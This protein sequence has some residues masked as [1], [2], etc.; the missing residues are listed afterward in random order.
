[1]GSNE[2]DYTYQQKQPQ[3]AKVNA[4][5]VIVLNSSTDSKTN[6]SAPTLSEADQQDLISLY[7]VYFGAP[8][9][10]EWN[11][12]GGTVSKIV[13]ALSY[14]TDQRRRVK[15]I[16]TNYHITILVGGKYN[17][18]RKSGKNATTIK[19]SSHFQQPTVDLQLQRRWSQF[20]RG[21]TTSMYMVCQ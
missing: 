8:S 6:E 17:P 19:G 9:S 3:T 20:D 16:I 12:E 18:Q 2:A 10:E 11:S 7:Y 5:V 1:M 15:D 13:R 14:S 21:T 4:A